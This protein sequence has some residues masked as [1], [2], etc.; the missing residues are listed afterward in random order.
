MGCERAGEIG[1]TPT[2]H[3]CLVQKLTV[4]ACCVLQIAGSTAGAAVERTGRGADSV[5]VTIQHMKNHVW[6]ELWPAMPADSRDYWRIVTNRVMALWNGGGGGMKA[7]AATASRGTERA[8]RSAGASEADVCAVGVALRR[9]I[10]EQLRA[11]TTHPCTK[12]H[13]HQTGEYQLQDGQLSE[14]FEVNVAFVMNAYMGLARQTG[15]RPGMAVE[16][17]NCTGM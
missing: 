17:S 15:C 13:L 12:E 7:A 16:N 8:M 3:G 11:G 4:C 2:E 14:P 1:L 6:R 5:Y 10:Q 9:Q